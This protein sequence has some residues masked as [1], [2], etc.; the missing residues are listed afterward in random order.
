MT[1]A[2]TNAKALTVAAVEGSAESILVCSVL[3]KDNSASQAKQAGL[4]YRHLKKSA[5]GQSVWVRGERLTPVLNQGEMSGRAKHA[6]A[7][8]FQDAGAGRSL[9]WSRASLSLNGETIVDGVVL[10]SP[11]Q[12]RAEVAVLDATNAPHDPKRVVAN[13]AR[14]IA[15]AWEG[16]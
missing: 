1:H 7:V 14:N 8:E 10:R 4:A 3:R 13:L 11:A 12:H 15:D 5:G 9:R 16:R 2:F 6:V